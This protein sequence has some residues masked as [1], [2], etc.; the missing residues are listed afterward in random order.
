MVLAS[1]V[2]ACSHQ[3]AQNAAPSAVQQFYSAA[4]GCPVNRFNGVSATVED[5]HDGLA[6]SFTGPQTEVNTLRQNVYRMDEAASQ[7]Q[8]PFAACPCAN[9]SA[10]YG[11]T[12]AMPMPTT[13]PAPTL[14]AGGDRGG[15]QEFGGPPSVR[16]APGA[17]VPADSSVVE[18]PAGAVLKLK[19]KQN[20][21]V[22]E[23]R[24]RVIAQVV[25]LQDGCLVRE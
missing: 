6:V 12:E 19:A 4:P 18:I 13:A 15:H 20:G 9:G 10:Q 25:A 8:D 5:I 17:P 21:R 14:T 3:G 23:L 22:E 2:G 11:S 7:G 1:A 24:R 16:K